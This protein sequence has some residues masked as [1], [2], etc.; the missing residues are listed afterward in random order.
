MTQQHTPTPFHTGNSPD[1]HE[2]TS[3][4]T[5]SGKVVALCPPQ[6]QHFD[7]ATGRF[8]SPLEEAQANA[9]FIVR[10]CN[11]HYELVKHLAYLYSEVE[12]HNQECAPE[13][14]I[15]MLGI[16]ECLAK[17]RGEA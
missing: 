3:V 11:V 7:P 13:K 15:N 4:C 16:R 10:A 17:A 12:A 5:A 2:Q 1:Y 9:E 6:Q 8:N 14:L